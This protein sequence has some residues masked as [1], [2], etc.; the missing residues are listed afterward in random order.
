MAL[1]EF[2]LCEVHWASWMCIIISFIKFGTIISKIF[3]SASFYLSSS[4]G[5]AIMHMFAHVMCKW[6]Y[7]TGPSGSVHFSLFFFLSDPHTGSIRLSYLYPHWFSFS[8]SNLPLNS[9]SEVFYFVLFTSR[10]SVSPLLKIS[11][12]I[13]ISYLF[14][15]LHIYMGQHYS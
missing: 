13:D 6:W 2:I 3:F 8:C 7:L 4:S 11:L 9:A 5:T 1:L 15:T 10:T 14:N 12:L